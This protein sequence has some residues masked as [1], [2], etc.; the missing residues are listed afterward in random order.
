MYDYENHKS[1]DDHF[2][3]LKRV[4]C[5]IRNHSHSN[6][7]VLPLL[8]ESRQHRRQGR[9]SLDCAVAL[10]DLV[11][12]GVKNIITFDVHDPNIQNA[13]PN[14]SFESF[15][16]TR[17]IIEKVLAE[18]IDFRNMHIVS[19]DAGAVGR[20]NLY[21][22]LFK[23]D[24]GMFRKVRD[25]SKVIDGKNPIIGHAYVGPSLEGKNV[26]IADDMI[27]SGESI[28]DT[29]KQVKDLGANKVYLIATFAMFTK[30][31]EVFDK[32]YESK[33]FDKVYTTNL[34]YYKDEY[35]DRPWLEQVDCSLK[36][37]KVINSL[38]TGKSLTRLIN[39]NN[40]TS[41]SILKRVKS[42]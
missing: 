16:P 20:A 33:S 7:I 34:T 15:F 6:S 31:I 18:D 39:D 36:V 35:N 11:S 19:P 22:N 24:M 13:I 17:E 23:C 5:A 37:A 28:L 3:D 32:A 38:N 21:A 10:Q 14:S 41:D 27:S 30:G 4:I 42:M 40:A 25:T 2:Q 26:I 12:L 29:A 8:Y 1:P 9:E